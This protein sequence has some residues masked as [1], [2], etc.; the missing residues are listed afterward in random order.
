MCL[1]ISLTPDDT[2]SF[3]HLYHLFTVIVWDIHILVSFTLGVSS[4][5]LNLHGL[6][7]IITDDYDAMDN[8]WIQFVHILSQTKM[9]SIAALNEQV[10]IC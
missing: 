2:P 4:V 9:I 10:E 5:Q 7:I 3:T 1:H 6:K 8:R